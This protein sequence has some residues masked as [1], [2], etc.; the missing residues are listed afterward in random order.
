MLW[1]TR[2]LPRLRHLSPEERRPKL[3]IVLRWPSI[4]GVVDPIDVGTRAP[5]AAR[6]IIR[7]LG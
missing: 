7:A 4:V 3:R 5:D 1:I 2:R 6:S